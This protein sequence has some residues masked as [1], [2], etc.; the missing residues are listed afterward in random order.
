[1]TVENN[2]LILDKFKSSN[3]IISIV[4]LRNLLKHFVINVLFAKQVTYYVNITTF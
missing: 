4:S 1:M 2:K 3:T